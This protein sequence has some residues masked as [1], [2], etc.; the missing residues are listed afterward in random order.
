MTD[1]YHDE[2]MAQC[3]HVIEAG[4]TMLKNGETSLNVFDARSD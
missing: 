4:F 3:H 1:G 2:V